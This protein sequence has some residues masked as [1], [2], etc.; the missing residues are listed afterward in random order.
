MET[1]RLSLSPVAISY[2]LHLIATVIWL[3][4]MGLLVL[5][6]YPL[7]ARDPERWAALLPPLEARFRP[8]ANLSLLVLLVTGV[9][10]TAEDPNYG[11]LLDFSTAWSQAI[12]AKHL[13]FFGMVGIVLFLQF[14][15]RPSLE[16]AEL[17]ARKQPDDPTPARLR[18]R[19]QRLTWVNF[20]LGM[21]VLA[22]TAI[23]TAI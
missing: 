11:G 12:A 19:E 7:A 1:L 6:I 2:F 23:A 4:G 21:V 20:G 3:G 16:R 15:L 13:A 14:G 10:Q 5:V 22:F 18:V 9:V 17:L 8:M